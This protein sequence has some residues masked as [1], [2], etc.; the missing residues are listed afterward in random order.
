MPWTI[1]GEY[2]GSFREVRINVLERAVELY[3]PESNH[4][5]PKPEIIEPVD[6]DVGAQKTSFKNRFKRR[7]AEKVEEAAEVIENPAEEVSAEEV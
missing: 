1:D 7:K 4:F 3:A 6:E 5:L 2:G